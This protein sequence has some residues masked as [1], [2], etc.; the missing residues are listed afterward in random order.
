[1]ADSL[2]Y[3]Q[4]SGLDCLIERGR[5][6]DFLFASIA[7]HVFGIGVSFCVVLLVVLLVAQ[8]RIM[9]WIGGFSGLD[10]LCLQA[11]TAF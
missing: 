11:A 5:R 7:V 6:V 10:L 3:R 1:M 8:Q 2:I 9:C 4:P